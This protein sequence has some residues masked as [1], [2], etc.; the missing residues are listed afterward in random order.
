MIIKILA[1]KEPAY[2]LNIKDPEEED[3]KTNQVLL[4]SNQIQNNFK[5]ARLV[6]LVVDNSGSLAL[7]VSPQVGGYILHKVLMDGGSNINILY[8]E[9]FRRMGLTQK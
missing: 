1:T 3:N 7:V 2:H 6:N 8:Y 5:T 9:T 4:D